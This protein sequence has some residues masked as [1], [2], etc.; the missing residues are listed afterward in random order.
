MGRMRFCL[1]SPVGGSWGEAPHLSLLPPP[2]FLR[3]LRLAEPNW[4]PLGRGRGSSLVSLRGRG[5]ILACPL[6]TRRDRLPRLRP[7]QLQLGLRFP[8]GLP[9]G[10][11]EPRSSAPV[12]LAMVTGAQRWPGSRKSEEALVPGEGPVPSGLPWIKH[13]CPQPP[14]RSRHGSRHETASES[15]QAPLPPA[16]SVRGAC[17][18]FSPGQQALA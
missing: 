9:R 8:V 15:R 2:A 1:S 5:R 18:S 12:T 10:C 13:P 6:S 4:K 11:L 7:R 3:C 14:P 17:C 16:P